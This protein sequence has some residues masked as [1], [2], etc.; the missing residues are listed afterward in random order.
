MWFWKILPIALL[1]LFL[2][3]PG[4]AELTTTPKK[5]AITTS[6]TEKTATDNIEFSLIPEYS[7]IDRTGGINLFVVLRNTLPKPLEVSEFVLLNPGLRLQSVSPLP[8]NI[9]PNQ[10]ANGIYIVPI[11]EKAP[12][13]LIGRLTIRLNGQ[14]Q[15]IIAQ[16]K[17]T[18]QGAQN[19]GRDIG[20]VLVGALS[21]IMGG[22]V[23]E[24]VRGWFLK[25]RES[26]QQV[27]KAVGLLLP[28]IEV[29]FHAV[30]N[31]Q[32]APISLW[33]DVYLKEGLHVALE[34]KGEA[35]GIDRVTDT[36]GELYARLIE[37]NIN[38]QLVDRNQLKADLRQLQ[39]T[40]R[41]FS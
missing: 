37:Y 12:Y 25:R 3:L 15:H 8:Q 7:Q 41:R 13:N 16:T 33:N 23:T 9:A 32:D 5:D 24:A 26:E 30:S 36:V 22:I 14:D 4:V 34:K 17:F 39:E 20:L 1:I 38:K 10:V 40:L 31:N 29:C 18:V 11:K 6:E 35:L 19:T 27:K 2:D 28:S 21:S